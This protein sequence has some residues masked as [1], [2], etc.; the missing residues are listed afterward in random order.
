MPITT[1]VLVEATQRTTLGLERKFSKRRLGFDSDQLLCL[2]LV[3]LYESRLMGKRFVERGIAGKNPRWKYPV[4]HATQTPNFASLTKLAR[5]S[6]FLS[7]PDS[8][9]IYRYAGL[10]KNSN[11]SLDK[12]TSLVPWS[13]WWRQPKPNDDAPHVLFLF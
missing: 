10:A 11:A 4:P 7:R 6:R 13:R 3:E 5:P 8:H 1:C 9:K 2:A 12:K